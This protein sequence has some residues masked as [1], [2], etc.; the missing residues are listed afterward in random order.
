MKVSPAERQ[1]VAALALQLVREHQP[2]LEP[3]LRIEWAPRFTAKLGE[4]R[5]RIYHHEARVRFS[6]PLWP[7][8]SAEWRDNVV[9][10]ELAHLIVYWRKVR[11]DYGRRRIMP[12]GPEWQDVM[13]AMGYVPRTTHSVDTTGLTRRRRGT[14]WCHRC[15]SDH[16]VRPK[17]LSHVQGRERWLDE[18]PGEEP[19]GYCCDACYA[20]GV[21]SFLRAVPPPAMGR[22]E[23]A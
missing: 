13:R 18:N 21:R 17:V 19:G 11:G 2:K 5:L 16:E 8:A 22:K 9:A 1:R 20:R 15:R 12:H 7:R 3:W 14:V 4:A 23:L 10:H 6:L